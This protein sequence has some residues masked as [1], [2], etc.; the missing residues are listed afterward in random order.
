MLDSSTSTSDDDVKL[1]EIWDGGI[2]SLS[3]TILW[4]EYVYIS[5]SVIVGEYDLTG[6]TN[7]G[8]A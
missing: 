3:D 5:E 4:F 7:L 2:P 6:K 1:E 8:L